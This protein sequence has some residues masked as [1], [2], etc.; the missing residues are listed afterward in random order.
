M[1]QF[2]VQSAGLR[3]FEGTVLAE[4]TVPGGGHWLALAHQAG[5]RELRLSGVAASLPDAWIC[6]SAASSG[7][8]P[9]STIASWSHAMW[10]S[11]RLMT[12]WYV[13][14]ALYSPIRRA[15]ATCLA[16]IADFSR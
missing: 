3:V 12:Y 1:R 16:R 10:T 14:L 4:A 2:G 8:P 11:S 5:Q 7:V 15:A 9:R 13:L 6:G